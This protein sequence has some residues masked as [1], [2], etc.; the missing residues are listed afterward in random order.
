MSSS[1]YLS[2]RL[3]FLNGHKTGFSLEVEMESAHE[4]LPLTLQVPHEAGNPED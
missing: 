3:S 4:G 1:G 2:E